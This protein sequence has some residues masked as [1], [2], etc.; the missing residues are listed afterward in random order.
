[1]REKS[2]LKQEINK[3]HN[4]NFKAGYVP[5]NEPHLHRT[6]L[7]GRKSALF[8]LL[9]I[10]LFLIALLNLVVNETNIFH[11]KLHTT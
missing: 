1:M 2:L 4:S 9:V 3:Q 5:I 11:L 10:I 8:Y 6:G 7:R